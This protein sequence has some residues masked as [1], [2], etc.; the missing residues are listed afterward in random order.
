MTVKW[1]YDKCALTDT[2]KDEVFGDLTSYFITVVVELQQN[3]T[4]S[5]NGT[6]DNL[7]CEQLF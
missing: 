6:K 7:Y 5:K 4:F 2:K 1:M 3:W